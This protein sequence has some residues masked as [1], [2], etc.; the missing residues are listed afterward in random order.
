MKIINNKYIF[1]ITNAYEFF[2]QTL[3]MKVYD[4]FLSP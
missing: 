3:K 4:T 2:S 1:L